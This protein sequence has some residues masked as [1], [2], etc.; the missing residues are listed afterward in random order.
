MNKY[1]MRTFK[2]VCGGETPEARHGRIQTAIM[3]SEQKRMNK[4]RFDDS[5]V[6]I[7]DTEKKLEQA[8]Y[9]IKTYERDLSFFRR[10]TK[11]LEQKIK[12]LEIKLK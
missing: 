5:L 12:Q 1:K 3:D 10:H 2:V 8:L 7:G 11:E 9:A 6:L 4:E